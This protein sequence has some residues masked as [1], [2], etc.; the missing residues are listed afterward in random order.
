MG[1]VEW[2]AKAPQAHGWQKPSG[3]EL[4]RHHGLKLIARCNADQRVNCR[5]ALTLRSTT[6]SRPAGLRHCRRWPHRDVRAINGLPGNSP[7]LDTPRQAAE[8]RLAQAPTSSVGLP[9]WAEQWRAIYLV[10]L[11]GHS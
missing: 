4:W 2:M 6:G 1:G 9:V 10:A 3:V 8:R 5:I 7:A 11:G